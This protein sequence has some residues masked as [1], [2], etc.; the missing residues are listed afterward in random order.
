MKKVFF[1]LNFMHCMERF[2]TQIY[3]TQRGAFTGTPLAQQITD[4]S[5]NEKTHVLKLHSH[6]KALQGRVYP[7]GW[8]FQLVGFV[9]GLITRVSGKR[10]LFRADTF[11][12][13]RAVKDY[14]SFLRTV[15][16]STKTVELIRGIIEEEEIHIANWTRAVASLKQ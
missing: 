5:D 11:V 3:H 7:L 8:L 12:E 1:S 14:N 9:L 10:N 4:A 16:F 2:A 15:P 6:I 13:N